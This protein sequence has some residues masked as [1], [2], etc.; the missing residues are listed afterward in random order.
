M[1]QRAIKSYVGL[2]AVFAVVAVLVQD[3][4]VFADFEN[5]DLVGFSVLLALGLLAES[6]TLPIT[7]GRKS[8]STSSIIFVPLLSSVLLFGPAP[9]VLLMGL[10][11]F[12]GEFFV[13]KKEA[14]RAVFNTS[15]YI[16]A[17]AV[18]GFAFSLK[19]VG[20]A[21]AG[22]SFNEVLGPQAL[23]FLLFW[24]TFV[25]LNNSA[26]A[27][28]VALSEGT[29]IRKVWWRIV[30]RT[31]TNLFYDILVSPIAFA[32][33][34]LY[35]ELNWIGLLVIVFPLLFIRYAYSRL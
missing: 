10:T 15:Q 14:L 20:L 35:Q 21:P 16:I 8:G 17:T 4:S 2:T 3:W 1:N 6:R 30:G 11:G 31:G 5:R 28:A 33:A 12:V 9:T 29:K 23:A 7:V 26:V 18:A 22:V 32:V 24:I 13:R 19:G 25:V 27:F 34:L